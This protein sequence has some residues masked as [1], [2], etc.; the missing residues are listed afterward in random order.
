MSPP[1][2]FPGLSF[3]L[4]TRFTGEDIADGGEILLSSASHA[5][6]YA[7]DDEAIEVGVPLL[8]YRFYE[9]LNLFYLQP[10]I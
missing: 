4:L 1:P 8:A 2:P 3:C 10:E 9:G 5:E 6:L 7:N